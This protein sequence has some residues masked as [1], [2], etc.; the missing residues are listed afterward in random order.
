MPAN[1]SKLKT[2][3]VA[4]A[5]VLEVL[6]FAA[7]TVLAVLAGDVA[8]WELE[9]LGES[10]AVPALVAVIDESTEAVFL[11]LAVAVATGESSEAVFSRLAV[12]M[13]EASEVAFSRLA[14]AMDEASEAVFLPLAVAM[15]EASEA[16]A[17]RLLAKDS[18]DSCAWVWT[19]MQLV[20]ALRGF[21]QAQLRRFVTA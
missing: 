8:I 10:F 19:A 16:A 14:V 12:S 20:R 6:L 7:F 1:D 21:K 2:C 15:D 18:D 5:L 17:S 4:V 9:V 13:D 3:V 11:R